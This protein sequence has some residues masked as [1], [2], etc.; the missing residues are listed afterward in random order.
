MARVSELF[1][2]I[3]LIIKFQLIL[4]C[5]LLIESHFHFLFLIV[6]FKSSFLNE[7]MDMSMRL[8][9]GD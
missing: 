3:F 8:Y 5:H 2:F 4:I 9:E 6:T 1:E 7:K